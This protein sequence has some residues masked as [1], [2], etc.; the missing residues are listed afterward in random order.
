MTV[1][2]ASLSAA[3]REAVL[4]LGLLQV[5]AAAGG[6]QGE[7]QGELAVG[8][9]LRLGARAVHEHP[10]DLAYLVIYLDDVHGS[11]ASLTVISIS[12]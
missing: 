10:F 7:G 4:G 11:S 9:P 1:A 12:A 8:E 2:P 6:P 3:V 5:K